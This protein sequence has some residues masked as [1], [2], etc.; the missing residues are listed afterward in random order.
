MKEFKINEFLTLKLEEGETNLY[1]KGEYF[2]QC[3]YLMLNIPIEDISK[4]DEIES[5]DEAN[6]ILGWRES[7]VC[8]PWGPR[9]EF[10]LSRIHGGSVDDGG[11]DILP[12]TLGLEAPATIDCDR[13]PR[14][15]GILRQ[16][17]AFRESP[18]PRESTSPLPGH[19]HCPPAPALGRPGR[20]AA[21]FL[22]KTL[23]TLLEIPCRG[24]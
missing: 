2:H 7:V 18:L 4:Y 20:R 8:P 16:S 21:L 13:R 10:S 17:R 11:S 1:V 6:D 23:R 3:T 14:Q 15:D 12:A 5:I 22:R 19:A 24:P 9:G